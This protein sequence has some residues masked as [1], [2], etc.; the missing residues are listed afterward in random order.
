MAAAPFF[1]EYCSQ[2]SITLDRDGN[3]MSRDKECGDA[4]S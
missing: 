1:L 3:R 2:A 4:V